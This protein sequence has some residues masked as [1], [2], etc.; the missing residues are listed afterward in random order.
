M[1]I[2]SALRFT[3]TTDEHGNVWKGQEQI[4]TFFLDENVQGIVSEEH[5]ESIARDIL[6][7]SEDTLSIIAVKIHN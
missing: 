2:V 3:T 5:A 6:G 7:G 4:P 1:Y